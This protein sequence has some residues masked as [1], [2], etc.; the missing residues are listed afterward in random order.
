MTIISLFEITRMSWL[1]ACMEDWALVI[2]LST[3]N[4]SQAGLIFADT[5]R[6]PIVVITSLPYRVSTDGISTKD[7]GIYF[8]FGEVF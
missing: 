3:S 7:W 4:S 2:F 1:D 6:V 5:P 8:R